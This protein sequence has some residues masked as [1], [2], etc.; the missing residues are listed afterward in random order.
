MDLGL[1]PQKE[2]LMSDTVLDDTHMKE[3]F[4]AAF[5]EVLHERRD[6]LQELVEEILEDLAMLRA[7]REGQSSDTVGREEVLQLLEPAD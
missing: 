6:L 4:K 3:L 7:I 1:K 2:W 5:V